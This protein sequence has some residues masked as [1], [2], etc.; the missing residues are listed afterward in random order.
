[1]TA[2][3][4]IFKRKIVGFT[5]LLG[6]VVFSVL[7]VNVFK[8]VA[9]Q[10][11]TETLMPSSSLQAETVPQQTDPEVTKFA[12]LA[13]AISVSVGALGAGIAVGYVGAAAM[14]VIGEKPELAG[15]ALIFVGLAEGIAIYGLI[16]AI[17]ILGR[18]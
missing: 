11:E 15:R 18:V 10:H 16:I 8:V 2:G 17:M 1:M 12:F 13:A 3:Q 4:Q 6:F 9:Q 14:G 5:L 7:C